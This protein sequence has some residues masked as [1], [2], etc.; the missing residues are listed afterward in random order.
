VWRGFH[1]PAALMLRWMEES[2]RQ[3]LMRCRALDREALERMAALICRASMVEP[4][5]DEGSALFNTIDEF[6]RLA[7]DGGIRLDRVAAHLN[8]CEARSQ[9]GVPWAN[10]VGGVAWDADPKSHWYRHSATARHALK[11]LA[12]V[13]PS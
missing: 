4:F 10:P 11:A 5:G 1:A 12:P 7:D 8:R 6:A 2:P 3:F 9:A 13:E